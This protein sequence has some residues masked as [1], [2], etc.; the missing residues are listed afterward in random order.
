MYTAGMT[1]SSR[2]STN[3]PSQAAGDAHYLLPFKGRS[4]IERAVHDLQIRTTDEA[5]MRNPFAI[6]VRHGL[7]EEHH[8]DMDSKLAAGLEDGWETHTGALG[9]SKTQARYAHTVAQAYWQIFD[10][11]HK[12]L[13]DL[14]EYTA[15]AK[16]ARSP[17]QVVVEDARLEDVARQD[18]KLITHLR[19]LATGIITRN[20][21][22][23]LQDPTHEPHVANHADLVK[24]LGT[25]VRSAI[26]SYFDAASLS[27]AVYPQAEEEVVTTSAD[28]NVSIGKVKKDPDTLV[29]EIM[30]YPQT[31]VRAIDRLSMER[32]EGLQE[33]PHVKVPRSWR[34]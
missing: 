31:I 15:Y 24:Y 28:G 9:W 18:L 3:P 27:G 2:D 23:D 1:Q 34:E 20:V 33:S 5:G 7:L 25:V 11:Y 10:V 14:Q 13:N 6:I 21:V 32:L 8:V 19:E 30:T 4:K 26:A 22:K 29:A 16:H 17:D 12:M